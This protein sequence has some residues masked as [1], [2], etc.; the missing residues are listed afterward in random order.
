M[1]T[2]YLAI[3]TPVHVAISLV[4][5]VAGLITVRRFITGQWRGSWNTVFLATTIATS[6]TGFF[7]P[8][9]G[10]TPGIVIGA[11]SLVI[12]ALAVVALIKQWTKTYIVC[13]IAAEFFNVLV[14]IVQLFRKTP[15][16]HQLAPTGNEPIVAVIQLLCLIGF[17]V[18]GWFAI[19]K[20]RRAL[21]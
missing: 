16:L 12:L 20:A 6:V 18:A 7:F 4:G 10:V 17:V 13:A 9:K 2:T 3:L 14:L 1:D 5:I 11:I 15:A 8:F 19:K 21:V